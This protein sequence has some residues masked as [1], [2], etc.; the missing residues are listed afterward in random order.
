VRTWMGK[1]PVRLPLPK[2][3]RG[4]LVRNF[5]LLAQKPL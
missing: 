1:P 5:A 4:L 3:L 2:A